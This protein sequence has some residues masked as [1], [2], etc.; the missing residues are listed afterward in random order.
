M[1]KRKFFI[2]IALVLLLSLVSFTVS[3]LTISSTDPSSSPVDDTESASRTFTFTVGEPANFTWY[4]NGSDVTSGAT[5]TS[6]STSS[7]YTNNSA[8]LGYW[9]VT[10]DAV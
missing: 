8:A 7:A 3:A 9:N 1:L 5:P 2:G 10:V 6:N 4:L